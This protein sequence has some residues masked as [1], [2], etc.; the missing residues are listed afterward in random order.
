[1]EKESI[2]IVTIGT[3]ILLIPTNFDYA[4]LHRQE[5]IEMNDKSKMRLSLLI[6]IRQREPYFMSIIL[7]TVKLKPYNN[8]KIFV[9]FDCCSLYQS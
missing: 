5:S 6:L 2:P 4:L 7:L 1:M 9:S 3:S 8:V